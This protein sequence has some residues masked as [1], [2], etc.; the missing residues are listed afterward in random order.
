MDNKDINSIEDPMLRF[1]RHVEELERKFR[2]NKIVKKEII[3]NKVISG[4]FR[5][6][7]SEEEL[8]ELIDPCPLIKKKVVDLYPIKEN[9][10]IP[11]EALNPMDW[12]IPEGYYAIE[13]E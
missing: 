10:E 11:K 1:E 13:I 3:R 8:I 12:D 6:R 9:T 7:S 2:E 4:K 5:E